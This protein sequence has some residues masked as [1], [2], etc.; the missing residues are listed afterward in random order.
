MKCPNHPTEYQPCQ[1]CFGT[2]HSA[3]AALLSRALSTEDMICLQRQYIE[4]I[5]P[6]IKQKANII[7]MQP[8][9]YILDGESWTQEILWQPNSKELCDMIDQCIG[10][11]GREIFK[12]R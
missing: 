11:V 8:I 4:A 2:Q 12:A 6:F 1:Y 3:G 5:Q 7:G 10:Q 9:R